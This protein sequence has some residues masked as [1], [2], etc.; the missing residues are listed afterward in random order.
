MFVGLGVFVGVAVAVGVSV[1]VAVG[2]FV[3]VGVWVAVAV[4]VGVL[5]GVA[6]G[7]LVAVGVAV[8]VAVG[9]LVAVGVGVGGSVIRTQVENSEVLPLA[10]VMV[11]VI[12]SPKTAVVGPV[13]ENVPSPLTS[14]A[15]ILA[16]NNVLPSPNPVGSQLS[17]WK[18]WSV[19]V[20]LGVLSMVPTMVILPPLIM[21]LVIT[22]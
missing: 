19:N 7:V 15:S 11:A 5:V 14:V 20:E 16:P 12:G 6:V 1:A 4:A 2:V 18:N 22:G 21:A 10:S 17:L 13:N 3:A 8:A 9:V